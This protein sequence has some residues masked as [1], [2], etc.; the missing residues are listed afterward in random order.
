MT[1]GVAVGL[2]VAARLIS[3]V[4]NTGANVGMRAIVGMGA[5]V[6]SCT[7]GLL[8]TDEPLET[9][10][11]PAAE[12]QLLLCRAAWVMSLGGMANVGTGV[13]PEAVGSGGTGVAGSGGAVQVERKI[14]RMS[15]DRKNLKVEPPCS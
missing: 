15:S 9:D 8:E 14:P 2:G 4:A 6:G 11:L 3:G 10:G 5:S 1:T 12:S 7:G 13:G